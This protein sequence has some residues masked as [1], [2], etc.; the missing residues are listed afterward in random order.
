MLKLI[1]AADLHLDSPFAGLR[2]ERAAQ[3]RREQRQL[4]ERLAALA[5]EKQADLVLLAGDL[6]DGGTVYQE[7]AAALAAALGAM[8]CPV[9]IAPGNHDYF[10][11]DSI[12]AAVEWP[13]NVHIFTAERP[14]AVEFPA[15]HCTVYGRA[16]CAPHQEE[17]PLAGLRAEGEGLKLAVLHGEVEG[18]GDYGP[19]TRQEIA[20]SGLDYLALGHIHQYSGLQREGATFWA[21]PG[22]PE[23]RGFDET[24]EKGALYVELEPGVCRAELVSL[25]A[26]RYRVLSADIT[27]TD[28]A[29]AVRAAVPGEY[30]EDICRVLLTGERGEQPLDLAALEGELSGLCYGLTLRDR[31]RVSRDL[32][33]K[34]EDDGLV[35]LFLQE[36]RERISQNPEDGT[37]TQAVRFGMAALEGWEEIL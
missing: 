34:A 26:R 31:T 2:P 19:I 16:F 30:R 27:G 28:P 35:G 32:W 10:G 4:L 22:C 25:C 37:L 11:P 7:T 6:L 20:A 21:Y 17:S 15:L 14:E 8:P 5:A 23:G 13:G 1:H 24:G 3:R 18:G 9:L 12:Y 29:A 33:A 36:M